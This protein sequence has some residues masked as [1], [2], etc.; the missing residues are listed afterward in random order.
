MLTLRA[1]MWAEV[2]DGPAGDFQMRKTLV[3]LVFL[4]SMTSL[5]ATPSPAAKAAFEK[6]EAALA[7]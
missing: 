3:F 7:A 4:L 2:A 6:G 5:A 1:F